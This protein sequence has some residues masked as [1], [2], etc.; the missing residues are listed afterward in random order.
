MN[1]RTDARIHANGAAFVSRTGV[2]RAAL[3]LGALLAPATLAGETAGPSAP[4]SLPAVLPTVADV[5]DPVFAVLLALIE[6][7]RCGTISSARMKQAVT[8][9]GRKTKIPVERLDELRRIRLPGDPQAEVVLTS[10]EDIDLPVPYRILMYEPGRMRTTKVLELDEWNLGT[11]RL[12]GPPR[13]NAPRSPVVL[14]DVR[15]WGIRKGHVELDVDGWLDNLLGSKLD[16][17][18]MVGFALFRYGGD[19]VG[20]AVGYNKAGRGRSGAF[21]FRDDR[22]LF[23]TPPPLKIAG[24]HLRG[25]LERLMPALAARPRG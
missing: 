21:H 6:Q 3:I 1:T 20:M 18:E 11:L 22:I 23:P 25:R 24:A 12:P 2:C 13:A 4:C 5:Q 8:R 14:E 17:T 9:S 16:D 15:V 10:R 19:L 7:D